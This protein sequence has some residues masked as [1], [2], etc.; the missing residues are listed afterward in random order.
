MDSLDPTSENR[1]IEAAAQW[2]ARA[3]SALVAWQQVEADYREA[4]GQAVRREID[5]PTFERAKAIYETRQ[6][7]YQRFLAEQEAFYAAHPGLREQVQEFYRRGSSTPPPAATGSVDETYTPAAPLIGEEISPP[8]RSRTAPSS[9]H[10][11][12]EPE[13]PKPVY[14]DYEEPALEPIIK[15]K[16]ERGERGERRSGPLS[17]LPR[18]LRIGLIA[19]GA[20]FALIMLMALVLPHVVNRQ[21]AAPTTQRGAT[22]TTSQA[23]LDFNL[24]TFAAAVGLKATSAPSGYDS[25]RL[26]DAPGN[27]VEAYADETDQTFLVASGTF[28]SAGAAQKVADDATHAAA[29]NPSPFDERRIDGDG[30]TPDTA[31][32]AALVRAGATVVIVTPASPVCKAPGATAEQLAPIDALKAKIVEAIAAQV[33]AS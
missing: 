21:A 24:T 4:Y 18:P 1:L 16:R 15:A 8:R 17:S 12:I 32:S 25:T 30:S 3:Q 5:K 33:T 26:S 29:G 6:G 11:F 7:Q 22:R 9:D 23:A 19:F 2:E 13:Q 10:A 14:N 28:P 27:S 20:F 31:C